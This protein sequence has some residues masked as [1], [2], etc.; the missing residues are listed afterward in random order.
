M[1][2]KSAGTKS[3]GSKITATKSGVGDAKDRIKKARPNVGDAKDRIGKPMYGSS[4]VP[5]KN[6]SGTRRD[7]G[8]RGRSY[9]RYNQNTLRKVKRGEMTSDEG[10]KEIA[11]RKT[12]YRQGTRRDI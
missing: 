7:V 6:K 8:G 9:A 10:R 4:T 2:K 3:S 1:R 5:T 11:G 12:R